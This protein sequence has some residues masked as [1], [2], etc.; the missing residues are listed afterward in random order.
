M[1]CSSCGSP[2]DDGARFCQKCGKPLAGSAPPPP[3]QPPPIDNR[4][5][6]QAPP[7][8]ATGEKRYADGKNPPVAMILG[9]LIP[10]VG[11]FYNGDNKKGAI[12]LAIAVI[13]GA[14]TFG[15]AW[16]G[17]AIWSAIDGYQVA[18]RKSPLW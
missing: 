14:L 16:V 3:P 5:R 1:F 9:L 10:G 8:I 6:G 12:M 18:T 2:N 17:A 7:V 4:A 15:L 11:Q 13:G